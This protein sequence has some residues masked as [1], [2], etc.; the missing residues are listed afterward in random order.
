VLLIAAE[1]DHVATPAGSSVACNLFPNA[2]Y[3]C[4]RGATHYCLYDRP[5]FL[6]GIL[7]AYFANPGGFSTSQPSQA[8]TH[9]DD[10]ARVA[11]SFSDAGESDTAIAIVSSL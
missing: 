4:V 3:L 10:T 8:K 9:P 11:A 7:K 1:Y 5:E 6:A 2:R